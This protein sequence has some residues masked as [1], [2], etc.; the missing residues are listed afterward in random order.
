[1]AGSAHLPGSF[2]G[3][4]LLNVGVPGQPGLSVDLQ[5]DS[6]VKYPE[7]EIPGSLPGNLPWSL[8]SVPFPGKKRILKKSVFQNSTPKTLPSSITFICTLSAAW[9]DEDMQSL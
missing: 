6:Q 7:L 8:A 1:M 2:H 5:D 3:Y 4:L 9:G